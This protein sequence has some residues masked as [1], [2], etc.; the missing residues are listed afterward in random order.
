M[1][2]VLSLFQSFGGYMEEVTELDIPIAPTANFAMEC[3]RFSSNGFLIG[4]SWY[5]RY[6]DA[7]PNETVCKI[8]WMFALCPPTE[9]GHG[10]HK[11]III[12]QKKQ[13]SKMTLAIK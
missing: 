8:S 6:T 2:K 9:K 1:Q 11:T 12:L 13:S 5:S 4:T 10:L 7:L 3:Y